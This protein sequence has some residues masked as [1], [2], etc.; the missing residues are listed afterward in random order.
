LKCKN[1][2]L[3]CY[4]QND[5]ELEFE[6]CEVSVRELI[7]YIGISDELAKIVL[8]NGLLAPLTSVLNDGDEVAVFPPIGGG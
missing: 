4:G 6:R 2:E 3:D 5:F 1:R 8:V 7:N